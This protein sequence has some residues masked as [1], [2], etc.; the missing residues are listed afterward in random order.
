MFMLSFKDEM[1][2]DLIQHGGIPVL[3]VVRTCGIIDYSLL[4][5]SL[6]GL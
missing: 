4:G 5:F 1:K 3:G 6:S 2:F